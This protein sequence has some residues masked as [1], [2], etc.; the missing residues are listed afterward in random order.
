VNGAIALIK[1]TDTITTFACR[2]H[3]RLDAI[4]RR[5]VSEVEAGKLEAARASCDAFHRG[6]CLHAAVEEQ[7]LFP[8]FEA[9]SG[10]VGG[11]TATLRQEH[12]ELEAAARSMCEALTVDD[13]VGFRE[14]LRLLEA[15][16]REHDSKEEHV[17]YPTTDQMLSDRE[18]AA[19]AERL[20]RL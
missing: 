3:R 18:C 9:R 6:L 13:P 7:L 19:V 15:V 8:L 1:P 20:E 2:E 11:P 10:M 14:G 4:L 5:A 12:R 16:R 17:L